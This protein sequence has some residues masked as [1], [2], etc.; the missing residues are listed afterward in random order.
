LII[1][2]SDFK[3]KELK[4]SLPDKFFLSGIFN[5]FV[6]D[7]L[8]R[9]K[10]SQ[11]LNMFIMQ[12]MPLP[13]V[14]VQDDTYQEIVNLVKMLYLK[15]PEFRNLKSDSFNKE[16]SLKNSSNAEIRARLDALV[17][18]IYTLEYDDFVFILHQ[19]HTRDSKSNQELNL[20]KKRSLE[21]FKELS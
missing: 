12:D 13:R 6:F 8:L 2:D 11:N 4:L 15:F 5:S 16:I 1:I 19:F 21:I 18:K 17:A 14:P 3:E 20:H 7:Y 10:V 9:L